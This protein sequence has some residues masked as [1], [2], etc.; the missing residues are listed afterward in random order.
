MVEKPPGSE[1]PPML[2]KTL[3]AGLLDLSATTR[4]YNPITVE[5]IGCKE[6]FVMRA[7][8]TLIWVHSDGLIRSGIRSPPAPLSGRE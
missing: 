6:P 2:S 5:L 3:R 7:N 1:Y 4:V 8:A